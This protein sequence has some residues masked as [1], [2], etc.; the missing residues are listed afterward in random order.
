MGLHIIVVS[1]LTPNLPKFNSLGPMTQTWLVLRFAPN[2]PLLYQQPNLFLKSLV[3]ILSFLQLH[4]ALPFSFLQLHASIV[5]VSGVKLMS[6]RKVIEPAVPKWLA[7]K[8]A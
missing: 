7:D 1:R 5:M 4:V 2:F 8:I 3:R 6:K